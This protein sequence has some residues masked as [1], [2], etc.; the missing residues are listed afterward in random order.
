M[1]NLLTNAIKF[2]YHGKILVGIAYLQEN[3]YSIS[4]EDTGIG[5]NYEKQ[6]TCVGSLTKLY[7]ADMQDDNKA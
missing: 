5:M 4:V 7:C 2:T 6:R 1:V 3:L